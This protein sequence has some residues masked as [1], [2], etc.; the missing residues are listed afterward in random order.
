MAKLTPLAITPLPGVV[1]TESGRIAEGRWIASSNIRFVQK[2]PQKIGGWEQAYDDPTDGVPRA[3]HAWRDNQTNPYNAAGTYPKLDV[4]DRDLER[5][6]I[7]PFRDTGTLGNDPFTVT[8]GSNIVTVE[9]VGHNLN[10]GDTVYF[11]GATEVGGITPN[12]TF[13]VATSI[14]ADHYTFLFSANATSDATGGGNAVAYQYEIPIGVELG[15]FGYGWGIGGWGLGTWGAARSTSTVAIEPRIWSLDHFGQLLIAAYNGGSVYQFDP[16]VAKPWGRA[17]RVDASAPDNVRAVFVTPERFIMALLDGMQVAWPSQGTINDWTPSLTNTANVRTLT[18]GTKLVAGRVLADF[19]SLIWTDAAL[20]RF[21]Y[22]GSTYV[23]NSS[24]VAKDCGL[25]APGATVTAGGVAF[26]MGQDNF[27]MY[28]GTVHPIPNVEDIRKAVFDE[29]SVNNGYQCTAVYNPQH[30][31]VWFFYTI[32][33][34]TS[35]TKGVIYSI[36]NQCWSP[37][38][39]GRVSGTHFTQGDTRPY[40]GLDTGYIVQHEIGNDADGDPLPYSLTLA[41]YA[42]SEGLVHMDVEYLIPDFKDQI[43]NIE[44]TVD[45]WNVLNDSAK[46]DSE[47]ESIAP[48]DSGNI[49]FRVSGRYLGMTLSCDEPGCYFRFGKPAA[50]IKPSGQR[51]P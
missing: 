31:E 39:F 20:Y 51:S 33:G 35:P 5:N 14:D 36:D 21:Q 41:P 50:F 23:Y 4:Y 46:E 15:A 24:M 25:I 2:R 37:L 10:A 1:L 43:G 44:I 26:W 13:V 29:L 34:E 3:M 48:V 49:D 6:D 42:M 8:N 9:D 18:E 47:T 19:V 12:G 17:T 28:D 16:S 38:P 30:N 7:T 45:T 40:M 11:S 32:N 27:W 22:T